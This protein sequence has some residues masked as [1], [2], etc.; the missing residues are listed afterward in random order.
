MS[1]VARST[2]VARSTLV[3]FGHLEA[4]RHGEYGESGSGEANVFIDISGVTED[5]Q[6]CM[7]AF[8]SVG[9]VNGAKTLA[10][11]SRIDATF[12]CNPKLNQ[13]SSILE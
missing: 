7:T 9:T 8:K 4:G 12:F 2:V 11:C 6:M 13:R 10:F 1:N 3:C 5:E